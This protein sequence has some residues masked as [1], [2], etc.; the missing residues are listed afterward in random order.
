MCIYIQET[1][2]RQRKS[3]LS[4]VELLSAK[5]DEMR[6]L[7]DMLQAARKDADQLLDQNNK[8]SGSKRDLE[9]RESDHTLKIHALQD[10]LVHAQVATASLR[11]N[12]RLAEEKEE[13]LALECNAQRLHAESLA[14]EVD[15]MRHDAAEASLMLSTLKTD[16]ADSQN[17]VASS[18]RNVRALQQAISAIKHEAGVAEEHTGSELKQL[19]V[20]V[21]LLLT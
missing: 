10:Q 9:N 16:L 20:R 3:H 4:S 14:S 5:E 6:S 13:G 1:L 18:E 7:E 11:Q 17:K 8:L 15:K 2:S 21:C 12:L 19:Q